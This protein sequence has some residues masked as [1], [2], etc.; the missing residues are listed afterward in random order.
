VAAAE[1]R[2]LERERRAEIA[3]LPKVV[4]QAQARVSGDDDSEDNE[5]SEDRGHS[6]SGSE[7]I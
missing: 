1:Q 5:P 4:S 7:D 2:R 6:G 3:S